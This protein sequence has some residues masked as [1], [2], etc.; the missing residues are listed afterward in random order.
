MHEAMKRMV[1]SMFYSRVLCSTTK[2]Y[3]L[4]KGTKGRGDFEEVTTLVV[5]LKKLNES[6]RPRKM[7]LSNVQG[8]GQYSHRGWVAWHEVGG[9][10]G[11]EHADWPED[12]SWNL[13]GEADWSTGVALYS[14]D[15]VYGKGVKGKGGK[16]NGKGKGKVGK[17][18]G[19]GKGKDGLG[20]GA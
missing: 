7:D 2:A 11:Q 6:T 16:G 17:G 14:L 5:E 9:G 15:D 20:K 8:Q 3:V 13:P 12:P 18:K 1:T 4:Q 19:T 10:A